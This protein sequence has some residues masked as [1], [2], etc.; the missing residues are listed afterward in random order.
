MSIRMLLADDHRLFRDGLRPLF[1]ACAD[2]EVVGE[3]ENG[4]DA[5]ELCRELVPDVAVLDISMPGLNGI[6]VCRHLAT[7]RPDV[8]VIMVSMHG[9]RR[10]VQEALRAG[11]RGYVLKDAGFDELRAGVA[12]VAA[13]RLHL[14]AAVGDQV[15]RDYLDGGGAETDPEAGGA[16]GVL[17]AREREVLQLVAEGLN[18]KEIA[19]RL[20][21]SVKTVE[22]HRRAVQEKLGLRSV[23]EL[24]RY[25]IREGLSPLD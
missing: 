5:L 20:A 22:S 13:G 11:A 12:A 18:T 3:A 8:R 6:E 25:A 9:D 24:T 17:S 7:E 23:A 14:S 15:L 19:D 1:D 21:V 4:L 2:V 16:F 10:F